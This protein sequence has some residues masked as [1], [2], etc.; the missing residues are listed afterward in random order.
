MATLQY[1]YLENPM[2]RERSLVGYSPWGRKESD[3]TSGLAHGHIK[4]H[5]FSATRWV[6]FPN[7]LVDQ[8]S[9]I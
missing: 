4:L 5:G 8:E 3:T 6:S 7:P 1:S 9:T 2:D